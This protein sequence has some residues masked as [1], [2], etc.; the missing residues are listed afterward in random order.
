[1]I[2][3]LVAVGSFAPGAGTSLAQTGAPGQPDVFLSPVL[4]TIFRVGTGAA[5]EDQL[6][7]IASVAF[8]ASANL[9]VLDIGSYRLSVWNARGELVRIA[10]GGGEG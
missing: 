9:H 1:M 5:V 4:D 3:T 8:D 2:V 10:G 7:R 6:V